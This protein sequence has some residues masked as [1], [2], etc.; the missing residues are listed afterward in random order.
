MDNTFAE[1]KPYMKTNYYIRESI[2]SKGQGKGATIIEVYNGKMHFTVTP[3]NCG[4]ITNLDFCGENFSY[5]SSN[6]Y[7]SNDKKTSFSKSF[8][9]GFLYTCGLDNVCNEFNGIPMHGTIHNTPASNYFYFCENETITIC[10]E[11]PSTEL[12]NKKL[13]LI[14]KIETRLNSGNLIITDTI[15]NQSSHNDNFILLYH[16]NLGYPF[17]DEGVEI[18]ADIEHKIAVSDL[19]EE[20]IKNSLVMTDP[21]EKEEMCYTNSLLKGSN[22]ILI[23][24]NKIKKSILFDYD[25]EKL[26]YF[27]EW[28]SMTK[29]EYALGIEPS[30]T[31][32][33]G[34][35]KFVQIEAYEKKEYKIIINIS[36]I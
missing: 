30:V 32:F 13:L 1:D 21:C 4:D 28:K 5:I 10:L 23:V 17:L 34:E 16:F 6:G 8:C 24:N 2:L 36:Q 25:T 3:D 31:S 18:K 11:I 35:K 9:G 15:E 29:N 7:V 22:N 33:Q 14:R 27:N 19:A 26:P 20:K 12:F